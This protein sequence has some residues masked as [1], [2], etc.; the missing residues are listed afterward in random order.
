MV[1]E[2]S[3]R[4]VLAAGGLTA[5]ALTGGYA[6]ADS[7]DTSVDTPDGWPMARHDPGGRSYAPSAEP[8]TDGV[9]VAWKRKFDGR[10]SLS[11]SVTPI[12]ADGRVYVIGDA[13]LVAEAASG[14]VK[15]RI[16]RH[17]TA[18]PAVA[19]ARA[20]DSPTVVLNNS[21]IEG[22]HATGGVG[23]FGQ[24][25]GS[26]RWH[27][28]ESSEEIA[29]FDGNTTQLP[30]VVADGVVVVPRED[31]VIA[32][33]ASSGRVLWQADA[34]TTRPAIR[35]GIVYVTR[36]PDG[37]FGYDLQ[38][39]EKRHKR[40]FGD[41]IP[42][43]VTAGPDTLVVGVRDGLLGVDGD[44]RVR[45]RFAPESLS[46]TTGAVALGDETAYTGFRGT[47]DDWLVAVDTTDG[48]ERWRSEAAPESWPQFA[49]PAVTDDTVYVPTQTGEIVALDA[50]DGRVR[51]RFTGKSE[52]AVP[53]SPPAL[54][55]ET[56]Y[57]TDDQYVYALEE[58]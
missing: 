30:P 24:T 50:S 28:D 44:G 4:R 58:P 15:F 16:D 11:Y 5:T 47:E 32:C 40:E 22:L 21:G 39:G 19:R 6:L 35:R 34:D 52:H 20:Y 46:R 26:T 53:M 12:I 55:G 14:T 56:L 10:L 1:P 31:R 54:V 2:F 18:A 8:P 17:A 48:T 51:W 29:F 49:P 42:R 33:E 41:Q 45:W 25:Y 57:V 38:T 43:T 37:L 27:H 13:L 36:Y 7:M 23:L 9:E 3:R